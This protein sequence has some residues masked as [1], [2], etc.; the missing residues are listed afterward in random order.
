MDHG[1]PGQNVGHVHDRSPNR[2]YRGDQPH[3][4]DRHDL[5]GNPPFNAVDHILARVL[6]V[7]RNRPVGVM[8][9]ML[10]GRATRSALSAR[11]S[12]IISAMRGTPWAVKSPGDHR[13]ERV[14]QA[15]IEPPVYRRFEVRMSAVEKAVAR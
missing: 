12:C 13:L 4:S 2:G 6:A 7:Q 9:K 3:Q 1:Q 14:G 5:N 8:V 15:E 10:M 11:K